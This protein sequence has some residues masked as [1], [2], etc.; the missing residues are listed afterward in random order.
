MAGTLEVTFTRR[1]TLDSGEVETLTATQTIATAG[2]RVRVAGAL[3]ASTGS[4]E[5]VVFDANDASFSDQLKDAAGALSI[6][7]IEIVNEG[8]E[9]DGTTGEPA[10][11]KVIVELMTDANAGIGTEP[12]TFDLPSGSVFQ[13]FGDASY[14][15]YTAGFGGGTLDHIER[16]TILNLSVSTAA[17]IGVYVVA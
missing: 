7:Y 16:V 15:N 10:R 12:Y 2:R 1:H 4:A 17:K 11:S 8:S 3:V 5:K 13:L 14:A 9:V 6:K